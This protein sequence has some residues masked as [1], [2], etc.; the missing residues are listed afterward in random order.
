L[1]LER[2]NKKHD[3]IVKKL[4]DMLWTVVTMHRN[5]RIPKK[6]QAKYLASLADWKILIKNYVQAH[7]L[8]LEKFGS[9]S[10]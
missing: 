2:E 1:V 6:S 9:H 3:E 8:A 10:S 5:E 7:N 4:Y